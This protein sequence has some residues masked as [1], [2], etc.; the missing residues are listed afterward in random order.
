VQLR[1]KV[2]RLV[3]GCLYNPA[4]GPFLLKEH[5]RAAEVIEECRGDLQVLFPSERVQFSSE[6]DKKF[7]DI[8]KYYNDGAFV[9]QDVF[10]CSLSNTYVH[11]GT[12]LVCTTDHKIISDSVME[13]R[14]PYSRVYGR[15][16]PRRFQK[17]AGTYST[18]QNVFGDNHWH[19]LVDSL[20]RIHSVAKLFPVEKVTFLLPNG[21]TQVQRDSFNCLL[22]SNCEARYLP[23]NSWVCPERFVLPSFVT[24]RANGHLPA[25]Y[26]EALRNTIFE[27]LDLSNGRAKERIYISRGGA[28]RR[29]VLN[30]NEVT[31]ALARYG[32]KSY[33]LEKMTFKEQV[34]LFRRAEF[35]IGPNGAGL[36]NIL[37]S[38]KIRIL[39]LY[40]DKTPNTYFLTQAKS[41]G[42]EH[43]FL[44]GDKGSEHLD[45]HA[46]VSELEA[47]LK[48]K[49]GLEP[50]QTSNDV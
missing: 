11:V 5:L 9:R 7:L 35:V 40:P 45:F 3:K 6:S 13:Y 17:L 50:R 4:L 23:T 22:P 21:L 16:K 8:C 15:Y 49:W 41:L 20:P 47:I 2:K 25:E 38:G 1:T 42:Q 28:Q 26:S 30:E 46:N 27:K 43:F 44:A 32:F 12:G 10:V 36:G 37:F 39:V 34:E 24:G 14:L 31:N 33:A 29:R 18:I 19:W 48:G